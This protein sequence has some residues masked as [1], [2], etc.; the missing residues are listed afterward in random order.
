MHGG[1]RVE[2][3][4][5]PWSG[6]LPGAMHAPGE[7][8]GVQ[9]RDVCLLLLQHSLHNRARQR[10][11][12]SEKRFHRGCTTGKRVVVGVGFELRAEQVCLR[13]SRKSRQLR[14]PAPISRWPRPRSTPSTSA[15]SDHSCDC[16]SIVDELLRHSRDRLRRRLGGERSP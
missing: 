4:Q 6:R 8:G 3:G 1:A 14:G 10:E 2:E 9:A 7:L 12:C 13:I 5:G 11:L 16:G 15:R